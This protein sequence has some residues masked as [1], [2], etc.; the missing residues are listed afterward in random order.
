MTRTNN[1]PHPD[2]AAATDACINR[3]H[4][5]NNVTFCELRRILENHHIP[6]HGDTCMQIGDTNVVLW[7]GMSPEFSDT[8]TVLYNHPDMELAATQP[9]LYMIEGGMLTLPIAKRPP[10]GGYKHPRWLPVVFKRARPYTGQERHD[11]AAEALTEMN[12]G[13]W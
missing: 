9:L 5:H 13:Q 7:A 2:H 4:T 10:R 6:A 11:I 1:P 3:V 8:A 12:T